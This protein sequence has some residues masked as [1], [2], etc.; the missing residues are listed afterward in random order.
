MEAEVRQLPH[1]HA[2]G[3]AAVGHAAVRELRQAAV[4]GAGPAPLVGGE[5]QHPPDVPGQVAQ[6]SPLLGRDAPGERDL[7]E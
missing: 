6:R 7:Q 1:G 4:P 5:H 2:R 3:Q